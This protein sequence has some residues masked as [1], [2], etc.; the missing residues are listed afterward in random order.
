MSTT[1]SIAGALGWYASE[2]TQVVSRYPIIDP[3][4]AGGIY[5]EIEVAPGR[6]VAIANVHLPAEPYGPYEL[7]DGASLDDVL[8]LEQST[9]VPALADHM[10]VLPGLAAAGIPVFLV[11]DFNSPSHLDWTP[12]V[13]ALRPDV[14]FARLPVSRFWRRTASRF[15]TATCTRPVAVP[16]HTWTPGWAEAT[17]MKSMTASL[18]PWPTGPA[19]PIPSSVVGRAVGPDGR[20]I[21]ESVATAIGGS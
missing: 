5:V 6:I 1:A 14:P 10:A 7:R 8:T 18:G 15:V 3:P 13:A 12:A 20:V 19:T 17:L 9:R 11:G 21:R 4:G 16:G 2:R